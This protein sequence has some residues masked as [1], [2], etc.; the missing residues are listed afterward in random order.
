MERPWSGLVASQ[1]H[2]PGEAKG[3]M[4]AGSLAASE[5]DRNERHAPASSPRL[6]IERMPGAVKLRGN[7]TWDPETSTWTLIE[8]YRAPA[9]IDL[10]DN[11]YHQ[12]LV[13]A[14]YRVQNQRESTSESV[15]V[16]RRTGEHIQMTVRQIKGSIASS[17][18]VIARI[19]P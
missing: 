11:Y 12:A 7:A 2:D 6:S 19:R 15:F 5:Q 16:G 8:T 14:G 10:V 17:I 1:F 9:R 4:S 18:Q 13:G 3:R